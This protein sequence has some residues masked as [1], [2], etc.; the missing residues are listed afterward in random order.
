MQPPL[1][2]ISPRPPSYGPVL[3]MK[4]PA[5]S[6]DTGSA[7]PQSRAEFAELVETYADRLVR[8]AFRQTGSL[9]DAEDIVQEVFAKTF[10][11]ARPRAVSAVG[12]YLYRAVG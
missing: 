7:W 1:P 4:P 11:A 3:P 9:H 5:T 6:S 12:P 10:D 2:T 8:H